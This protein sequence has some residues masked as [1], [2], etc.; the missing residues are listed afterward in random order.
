MYVYILRVC[1]YVCGPHACLL[2][3]R[4]SE[5]GFLS[6]RTGLRDAH[7]PARRCSEL[8]PAPPQ[9]Q[10]VLL[11]TEPRR[12]PQQPLWFVSLLV[13]IRHLILYFFLEL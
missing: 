6:S 12:Q 5:E 9:Q 11:T 1:M 3:P 2:V 10:Q 7:E 8:R 13:L 4:E